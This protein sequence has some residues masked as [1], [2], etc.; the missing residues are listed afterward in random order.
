MWIM[1]SICKFHLSTTLL[2]LFGEGG[3]GFVLG[4]SSWG[5]LS[6]RALVWMGLCSGGLCPTPTGPLSY[7]TPESEARTRDAAR[8]TL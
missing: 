1:D 5:L 4:L 3:R 6:G 7:C 8:S 2:S